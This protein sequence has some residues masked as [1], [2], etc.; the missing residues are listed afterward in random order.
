M[1]VSF[2]FFS[3]I[4][5]LT[6]ALG[7]TACDNGAHGLKKGDP[8]PEFSL[9]GLGKG[10]FVTFPADFQG[11][12]VA[13]RFWADWCPYC[14]HEMRELEPVYQKYRDRGLVILAINVHQDQPTAS[15]FAKRLGISYNVLLDTQGKTAAAY[16]VIGLPTTYLIDHNGRISTKIIGESTAQLFERLVA[17]L[18]P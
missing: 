7:P 2:L 11:K 17:E 10:E 9:P 15:R 18:L 12:V 3:L 6:A 5:F 4:V 1:R 16:Q 14:D 8:A 13:I